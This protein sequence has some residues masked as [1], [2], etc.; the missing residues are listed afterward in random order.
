L[1]MQPGVHLND[2]LFV[3]PTGQPGPRGDNGTP[4]SP[5]LYLN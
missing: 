5:G 1:K 2:N 3:G 4:G